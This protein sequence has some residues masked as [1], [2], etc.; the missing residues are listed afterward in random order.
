MAAEI[1]RQGR[2]VCIM[3]KNGKFMQ[4][5]VTAANRQRRGESEAQWVCWDDGPG[6]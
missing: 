2:I 1:A 4:Q 3:V 6:D 5:E